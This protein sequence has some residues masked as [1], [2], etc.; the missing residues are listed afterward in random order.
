MPFLC[1]NFTSIVMRQ[2]CNGKKKF[3]CEFEFFIFY[4]FFIR[5]RD[6]D[7]KVEEKQNGK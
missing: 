2:F 3:N 4:E 6:E 5:F 1:I 7:N